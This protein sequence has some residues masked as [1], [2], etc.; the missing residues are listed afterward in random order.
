MSK[1][2]YSQL[3]VSINDDVAAEWLRSLRVTNIEDNDKQYI[4]TNIKFQSII[5]SIKKILFH[6][7]MKDFVNKL[8]LSDKKYKTNGNVGDENY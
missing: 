7:I 2:K 3:V 4:F 1:Y 8:E 5:T 6:H